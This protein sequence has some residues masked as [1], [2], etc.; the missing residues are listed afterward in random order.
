MIKVYSQRLSPPYSG[1][2]QIAES[3]RARA[4]TMDGNSWE[5]HFLHASKGGISR[6]Q[7]YQK[8]TFRRVAY[9]RHSQLGRISQQGSH[10]GQEID[11]RIL[12]L[13]AFL[14]EASLPFPAADEFEY[15]LLDSRDESP[16]ALIFSCSE[17]AQMDDFPAHTEWTALPAAVMPIEATDDEKARNDTPVNYRVER[18]VADRAGRKPKA[19]WFRR[20][21]GETESFPPFLLNEVWQDESEY[22]LC[23][24]YLKRQSTR[25]LML[26]GLAHDDRL[27]LERAARSHTLEVARFY[28]MYPEVADP[29]LMDAIRVEA[30]MR[31]S[32]REEESPLLGR[33]DGILYI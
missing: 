25:L 18:L 31:S 10:E 17:G 28:T 13:T 9:I 12:E 16:L 19:C 22:A 29:A 32:L 11:E 3:E 1:Q 6:D 24:R 14:V 20:Q 26:H 5:I 27:R 7:N 21:D 33:R 15:W 30:R 23:Q 2:V 4:I 8:R